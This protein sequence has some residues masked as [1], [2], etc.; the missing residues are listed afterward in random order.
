LPYL[1]TKACVF[2]LRDACGRY[3]AVKQSICREC[4]HSTVHHVTAEELAKL[5]AR[6]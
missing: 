2:P 1:E 3:N 4:G 5:Q 6:K